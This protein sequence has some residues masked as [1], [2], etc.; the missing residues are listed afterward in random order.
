MQKCESLSGTFRNGIERGT[1]SKKIC[2]VT[3]SSEALLGSGKNNKCTQHNAVKRTD[4]DVSGRRVTVLDWPS[5]KQQTSIVQVAQQWQWSHAILEEGARWQQ[6]TKSEWWDCSIAQEGARWWQVMERRWGGEVARKWLCTLQRWENDCT[7]RCKVCW[8]RTRCSATVSSGK[9]RKKKL[10]WRW[11]MTVANWLWHLHFMVMEGN[12]LC[13]TPSSK[14]VPMCM[15]FARHWMTPSLHN[16]PM[17]KMLCQTGVKRQRRSKTITEKWTLRQCMPTVQHLRRSLQWVWHMNQRLK[18]VDPWWQLG[19]KPTDTWT[20]GCL[21]C[22]WETHCRAW[23]VWVWDEKFLHVL[24]KELGHH[25]T[26]HPNCFDCEQICNFPMFGWQNANQNCVCCCIDGSDLGEFSFV[27][28][29]Q[30]HNTFWETNEAAC[31]TDV[32]KNS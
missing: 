28:G 30:K 12:A 16:C 24:R 23:F 29:K 22:W 10:H 11:V 26:L 3:E 4:I 20:E 27:N 19:I 6:E 32:Q 13:G 17:Q 8:A 25:I 15:D 31:P 1:A 18:I 7:R 2:L 21:V 5:P 14:D 9:E